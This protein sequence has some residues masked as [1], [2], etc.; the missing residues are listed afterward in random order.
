MFDWENYQINYIHDGK[1]LS[2]EL[3][4]GMTDK[5]LCQ[6]NLMRD[7]KIGHYPTSYTVAGNEKIETYIFQY[8][9]EELIKTP[10]GKFNTVKFFCQKD[11]EERSAIFN[12][13]LKNYIIFLSRL[14][15]PMMALKQS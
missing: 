1:K 9:G 11:G 2:F 3:Q 7:L 14:N 8:L 5:L 15:S 6:I 10:I 13:L 12:S 4:T